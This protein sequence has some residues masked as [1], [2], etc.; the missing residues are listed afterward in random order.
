MFA[1]LLGDVRPSTREI[2]SVSRV[3]HLSCGAPLRSWRRSLEEGGE[4]FVFV[5]RNFLVEVRVGVVSGITHEPIVF[6]GGKTGVGQN[7]ANS[8]FAVMGLLAL[9]VDVVND[10]FRF[11]LNLQIHLY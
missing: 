6:C 11:G 7:S 4:L 9:A 5:Q 1:V 8:E 3:P 2:A 10:G